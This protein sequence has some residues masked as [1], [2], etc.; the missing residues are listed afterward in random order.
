[1]GSLGTVAVSRPPA[2]AGAPP[3]EGTA[4]RG[5][6]AGAAG[7]GLMAAQ[8]GL[9]VLVIRWFEIEGSA[10]GTL[11]TIAF[12]G[13]LVHHVLPLP[14]RLPFFVFLSVATLVVV[15]GP[16]SAAWVLGLGGAVIALCHLRV[17]GTILMA[18]LLVAG[19]GLAALRLNASEGLIPAMVWPVFGAMFMFRTIAYVH[20][21]RHKAAPFSLWRS[22]G[23]FFMLPNVCFP[24]FPIVDYKT[25]CTTYFN[26]EPLAI[27]AT[28]LQWIF[29]G[30]LQL[31][32]YRVVY[33]HVLIH[34]LEVTDLLGTT[35]FV[36]ATFL[37]YLRV[38]GQFHVI[39][40]LLHLFG[41]NLPE[42]HHLYLLSS[43]FTDFWRRLNIYWKDFITKVVFYPAYFKVRHWTPWRAI[44]LATFAAVFV[45]WI[46]H[47]YQT[48]W[49][50]GDFALSWQDTIFW[51]SLAALVLANALWE[52]RRGR[53][54]TLAGSRRSLRQETLRVQGTLGTFTITCLLWT[55]WSCDSPA[56]LS[57]LATT[58]TRVTPLAIAVLVTLYAGLA[59]TALWLG[60]SVAHRTEG[61]QTSGS[62]TPILG[63]GIAVVA[64]C[65]VLLA[66]SV[67]PDVT[68][69]N[70]KVA[71]L[72]NTILHSRLNER[73]A[74]LQRRGY[75]EQLTNTRSTA[76]LRLA[77][78]GGLMA[79]PP[80]TSGIQ[81]RRLRNDFLFEELEPNL[82]TRLKSAT[83]TT[84]RWGMRDRD[85]ERAKP[86]GTYR[87]A[88]L[89]S[90]N[91]MGEGVN[92]DETFE[93]VLEDR[94]NEDGSRRHEILNFAV[95]GH[96]VYQKLLIL[97]ER[98]FPFQPDAVFFVTYAAEF[99]RTAWHL[100]RVIRNG[101]SIPEPYRD[102]IATA[103][104]DAGVDRTTPDEHIMIR[105]K[106]HVP[107]LIAFAFARM[108]ASC[109]AHGVE[110]II[111]F[112][113]TISGAATDASLRQQLIELANRANVTVLD[114]GD[115]YAAVDD[116]RRL[117]VSA[118]DDHVNAEGHR[119]LADRLYDLMEDRRRP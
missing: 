27:S 14:W 101:L 43:S 69:L 59:L 76:A 58:A 4:P 57:W 62:R 42:T 15:A 64:G 66:I 9:L 40:G 94:L 47:A 85:Y 49:L 104:S 92:D 99:D 53:A 37:L 46:L 84:N 50:L 61:A 25:W 33:H 88:L 81:L 106:P 77:L 110:P 52:A 90:S 82:T 11:A 35:R 24:L 51:W 119:L 89:G 2:P 93:H 67:L 18:A 8:F 103:L 1:M 17:K 48:F 6:L 75:Y 7:F 102:V 31:L 79:Q 63:S 108:R 109:L 26:R 41:F 23:Y 21:L 70:N 117:M 114:L 28:G 44:A 87:V 12:L 45:T 56:E 83:V 95:R 22:L 72:L 115:A 80:E 78:P 60:R 100:S 107:G 86:A 32:A 68:V 13:F 105:L 118:A 19:A 96:G 36:L 111:V 97:E 34:P 5:G 16:A 30:V 38:S 65:I 71:V 91:E 29:R 39:I 3:T 74:E 55:I 54:R 20:D 98:V 116:V 10:F 112:R 113:P 73:D